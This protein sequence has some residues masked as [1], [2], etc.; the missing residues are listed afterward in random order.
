MEINL[1]AIETAL[2]SSGKLTCPKATK[3]E[4]MY[5]ENYFNELDKRCQ[6]IVNH[7]V[8]TQ[9]NCNEGE[10]MQVPGSTLGLKFARHIAPVELKKWKKEFIG[11]IKMHPPSSKEEVGKLFVDYLNSVLERD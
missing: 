4:A 3:I 2:F 8:S 1:E 10:V 5:D 9:S 7:V 11:I 6:E